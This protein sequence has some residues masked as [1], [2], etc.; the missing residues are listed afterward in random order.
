MIAAEP[1]EIKYQYDDGLFVA[2]QS[3]PCTKKSSSLFSSTQSGIL[4][5]GTSHKD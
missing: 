2:L 1:S 4:S 3:T 5:Q